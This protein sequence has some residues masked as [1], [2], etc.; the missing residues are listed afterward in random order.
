MFRAVTTCVGR[1]AVGCDFDVKASEL[2]MHES[3]TT[4]ALKIFIVAIT[5]EDWKKEVG[6]W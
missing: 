4:A 1:N 2:P 3:A 6:W 5:T